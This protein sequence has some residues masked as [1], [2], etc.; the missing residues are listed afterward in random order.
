MN[1]FI[2]AVLLLFAGTA[3]AAEERSFA[4]QAVTLLS[5]GQTGIASTIEKDKPYLSS[6]PFVIDS[7]GR[8][9]VFIS[10]LAR[11]TDNIQKNPNASLIVNQPDEKGSYFNGS[12]VTL[13]G[14]FVQVTDEKEI[15][16]CR[17]V[18]M[19]RFKEAKLWADFGDFNY[20][21][22]EINKIFFIGGFGDIDYV[23]LKDYKGA[24][25]K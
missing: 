2:I 13:E 24:L 16:A 4:E 19:E 3:T 20:Y 6:M 8:P 5:K 18:Y 21:R 14:K 15:A 1:S 23:D 22:L 25:K 12:R 9:I 7:E 17:K 11:H 10:D